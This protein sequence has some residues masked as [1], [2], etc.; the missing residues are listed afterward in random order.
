MPFAFAPISCP[1][2]V[3]WKVFSALPRRVS[4]GLSSRCRIRAA[5]RRL[6]GLPGISV[7]AGP[8]GHSRLP[9]LFDSASALV[10]VALRPRCIAQEGMRLTVIHVRQQKLC[11]P[12][13]GQDRI[14]TTA[15]LAAADRV[16]SMAA[17]T[18]EQTR[19]RRRAIDQPRSISARS[20]SPSVPEQAET[21]PT[22]VHRWDFPC[23][24]PTVAKVSFQRS[25]LIPFGSSS[26]RPRVKTQR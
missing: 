2:T 23:E 11:S 10:R 25:P 5:Y 16:A 22:G 12:T 26:V 9:A 19:H 14:K 7:V 21:L 6:R 24:S 8:M 13:V 1:L 15:I 18:S 20:L 4:S 17:G 3:S